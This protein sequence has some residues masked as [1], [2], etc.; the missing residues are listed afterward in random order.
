MKEK[1]EF[2]FKLALRKGVNVLVL[3]PFGCGAYGNDASD[4]AFLFARAIYK[5]GKNF[6][7]IYFPFKYDANNMRSRYN[8][9]SFQKVFRE[10]SINISAD[11]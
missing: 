8:F 11:H 5:Y 10:H 2:I 4:V 7:A 3:G 1:I 6:K 9:E